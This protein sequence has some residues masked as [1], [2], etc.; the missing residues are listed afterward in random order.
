MGEELSRSGAGGFAA[1]SARPPMVDAFVG[2]EREMTQLCAGLDS[3]IAGRGCLFLVSGEPGI[4][5][6]RL[7]EAV[8]REASDR[9]IR[10]VWG[11]C[12]EGGG[13]PAY[14]PFVQTI[15][16]LTEGT[17]GDKLVSK[18]GVHAGEIGRLVPALH[19][20]ASSGSPPPTQDAEQARFR[21]FDAVATLIR[22]SARSQP[23]M[24]IVDDL[25]DADESSIQMLTY[26][27]RTLTD[28]KI[29]ILGT[30][31]DF[32][33]RESQNLTRT[34]SALRREGSE[35]SLAGL[36]EA[37]VASLIR[38][39]YGLT[40]KPQLVAD[41]GSVTGGNPFFLDAVIQVLASEGKLVGRERVDLREFKVPDGVREPLRRRLAMLS[42]E[43]TKA[44]KVAAALGNEFVLDHVAHVLNLSIEGA[45]NA[46]D[47]AVNL[48]LVV[49]TA[50]LRY[51]F[52]HALVRS[53]LYDQILGAERIKVHRMIGETLEELFRGDLGPH[54]AA[55][56]HHFREAGVTD[57]AIAYSTE[58]GAAARRAFAY[59][60][61][62]R[63]WELAVDLMSDR[64]FDPERKARLLQKLGAL[65]YL[66][67][68]QDSK[69]V[70]FLKQALQI[71]EGLGQQDR[72]AQVHSQLGSL[73]SFR[74]AI[75]DIPVATM[76]YLEAEKILKQGTDQ[77]SLAWVYV[78]LAMVA[79]HLNRTEEGLAWSR[80]AME[81]ASYL[82]HEGLR[83]G[84][85]TLCALHLF[86]K[87]KLGAAFSLIDDTYEGANRKDSVHA[88]WAAWNAGYFRGFLLDPREARHWYLRELTNPRFAQATAGRQILTE[89]L[90]RAYI[91]EGELAR[92]RE[93]LR[94]EAGTLAYYDGQ[95]AK[96]ESAEQQALEEARQA[97][98]RDEEEAHWQLLAKIRL[99]TGDLDE[100]E[101][102]FQR[103][104]GLS[105]TEPDNRL[106]WQ[107]GHRAELALICAE[108]SR[109]EE[110]KQHLQF[111]L[112]IVGN[113]EN[114]RGLEGV[115]AR[116]EAFVVA[117]EGKLDEADKRFREAIQI[118]RRFH[119]PFEEARTLRYWARTLLRSVHLDQANSMF[120]AAIA[121]YRRCGAGESWS[122]R[123]EAD[124]APAST[125][126]LSGKENAQRER[127][128]QNE[129]VL[130]REGEYWT[131]TYDCTTSR[132]KDARGLHYIV[133]LLAHPG[134][135]IRAL[136]LSALSGE[137]SADGVEP[138]AAED[139]ARSNTLASDLG[140][141]GE[142]LD[143][144]AKVA[145]QRRLAELRDEL[146]DAR[147]FGN[148]ERV[149][150]AEVEIEA[151]AHEL[152]GAIGLG[153][154][155][156]RAA[157]SSER[158]RTA[159]TRSIKLALAK[160]NE[161]NP[162]LGKLLST[163]IRTGTFC[164]YVPD[165]RFPVSW[166]L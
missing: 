9:G 145:Y 104:L 128:A 131:I 25:H 155:R 18:L 56:A 110:A 146:D 5:K 111:C 84:A 118:F 23:V 61:A 88:Y 42:E 151:L 106:P 133:N 121:I 91:D 122:E 68:S 125:T 78:G 86:D 24:L 48:G 153:G 113:G 40:A 114:W 97:G 134:Q 3:A 50:P 115:V 162:A 36:D 27:A 102:C 103:A 20:Q 63:H 130:R 109:L 107:V 34:V 95:W 96:A 149:E 49:R 116:A 43:A 150:Q 35:I 51:R 79:L 164:S 148:R 66:T 90:G 73:L 127:F 163:T 137:T 101:A 12:W 157:S 60:D 75:T 21:L 77:I 100:A 55:L 81:I 46:L 76:H 14:W 67:N 141:A 132:L 33:V 87:G 143:E 58:S 15:R 6:S 37:S 82:E 57:K 69:G 59:E 39:R 17:G 147:E 119:L 70:Q 38:Q 22:S 105:D 160:I 13:A 71:Y 83:T 7:A 53:T 65:H 129:A 4:G 16:S 8:S 28:E 136:D 159:V 166:K 142:L 44:L 139:L 54:F 154:R 52:S 32:E 26:V 94:F 41:L 158:A 72:V 62:A 10:V 98:S 156:R 99:A 117:G 31:R 124:K 144:Q 19:A 11:R 112:Q 152:K 80:R 47:A 161:N 74:S 138:P 29:L 135:E 30:Y 123:I 64:D 93:V 85:A 165:D 140:D 1:P 45:A 92:A 126:S 2:R 120:D 108:R 89:A